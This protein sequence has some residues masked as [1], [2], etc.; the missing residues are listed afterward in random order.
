MYDRPENAAAHDALWSLIR[1]GLRDHGIDAP[2]GLDRLTDHMD[3]WARPDLTLGQICNLPFR[4]RFRG[5]VTPIATADYA[6]SDTPAGYFHA[7][8]IVRSDD[9]A[10]SVAD[11]AGYR[12]ALN[13]GLSQS[14]WGAPSAWAAA[15]GL[16]LNPVLLTG[17]HALSLLA[18]ASG[19]ADLAAIDAVTFRN[20]LRWD[21]AARAVRV[22]GRTGVS[23][24]MT[25]ITAPGADPAPFRA[26]LSQAIAALDDD[27]SDI[28]GLR[29]IVELPPEAYDI[30]LPTP[31][32]LP[33]NVANAPG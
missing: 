29:G 19:R 9:L 12:Y 22:I 24:A 16:R 33:K 30:P 11:C 8:F 1:D 15:Q 20:L 2:D 3:G 23:P 6:L 28:L 13:D 27:A 5:R 10:Q 21:P 7:V 18:V 17:A 14:G 31:P 4:A 25:F 26:A 32:D